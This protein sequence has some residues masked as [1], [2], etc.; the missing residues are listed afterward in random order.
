MKTNTLFALAA[1]AL[2]GG[3]VAYFAVADHHEE[4]KWEVHDMKRPNVDE[5]NVKRTEG[6]CRRAAEGRTAKCRTNMPPTQTTTPSTCTNNS[7]V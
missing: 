4:Q 6:S 2:L 5:R 7:V 1:A 3:G